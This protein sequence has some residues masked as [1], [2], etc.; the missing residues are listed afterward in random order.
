MWGTAVEFVGMIRAARYGKGIILPGASL[1]ITEGHLWRR[2]GRDQLLV[3]DDLGVGGFDETAYEILWRLADIRQ[4]LP[5]IWTS[6]LSP[7][8][9][10]SEL[11]PRIHSRVCCGAV[12]ELAGKDRRLA[13][14]KQFRRN[15]SD[16]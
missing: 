14:Q 12:I 7:D 2:F 3:V 9:V 6:N 8:K 5:T 10:R 16:Q 15:V 13:R 1:E 4:R 11:D